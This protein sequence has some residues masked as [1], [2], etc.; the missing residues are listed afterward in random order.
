MCFGPGV[1]ALYKKRIDEY[2]TGKVEDPS[3]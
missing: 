2:G 3:A 1:L